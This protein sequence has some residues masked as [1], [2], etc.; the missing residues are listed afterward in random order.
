MEFVTTRDEMRAIYKT[1]RPTDAS[2]R[3]ELK[4]LKE[5]K[6]LKATAAPS[7]ARALSC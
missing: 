1:P 2:M 7:S 4:E 6:A 5:L 3:K